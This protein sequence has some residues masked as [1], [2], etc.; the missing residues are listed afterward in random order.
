VT[1]NV[2]LVGDSCIDRYKIGSVD[3]ISPEAPVPII[4]VIREYQ[5]PGMAANVQKNF[6]NLGIK[7][8]LVTHHEPIIKVRYIDERSGQHLLRVDHEG[9]IKPWDLFWPAP[10]E[11]YAAI[12]ISD[13]DKGYVTYQT[14]EHIREMY[15]GPIFIDTK[16]SD[17]ARF[18]GC[19]VKI[20][21]H[22]NSKK[23]S[24]NDHL[25]VTLGSQGAVY[26]DQLYPA[27]PCEVVDVC[28]AGDTF[29][30]ALVTEYLK[31]HSM[32][33]ALEF[34]N[35]A[36]SVCV[37]HRGAYAPTLDEICGGLRNTYNADLHN[38]R[39]IQ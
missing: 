34:A 10:L 21:E 32:R 14:V 7:A 2:L 30:A 8:D 5:L 31:T 23:L 20:N 37:Q 9:P 28:G 19:F 25:I 6:E 38:H 24:T 18:Q 36:A 39:S 4:K 35:T 3:R 11:E 17:L 1:Q 22:E 26:Q 13:Y 12:V 27:V 33:T 29:L 15:K 16:K